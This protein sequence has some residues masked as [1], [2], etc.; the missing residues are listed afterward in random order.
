MDG[1]PI[2]SAKQGLVNLQKFYIGCSTC[3]MQSGKI[4][5]SLILKAILSKCGDSLVP[6]KDRAKSLN[7]IAVIIY[8]IKI[9]YKKQ[10]Y[11]CLQTYHL[12][13]WANLL[14]VLLPTIAGFGSLHACQILG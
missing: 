5:L 4:L 10:I 11:F 6:G 2:I 14:L 9:I 8:A 7:S 3:F 1:L 13:S 12:V